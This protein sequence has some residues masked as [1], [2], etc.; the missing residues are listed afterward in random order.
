MFNSVKAS[1]E[2]VVLRKKRGL[3]QEELAD[4]LHISPP[5][6]KQMGERSFP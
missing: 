4:R 5:G 1:Q 3:T 2:I 6:G